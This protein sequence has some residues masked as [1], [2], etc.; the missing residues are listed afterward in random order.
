MKVRI[1]ESA[2]V[3]LRS[4]YRFYEQQEAGVG[5]YFLNSL[6]ADIDSLAFHGGIHPQRSGF[7]WM[8]ASKFPWAIYYRLDGDVVVVRAVLDCRRDPAGIAERLHRERV[9]PPRK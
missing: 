9:E 4:G 6:F 7:H 3:D 8:L 1:L 2:R 5:A